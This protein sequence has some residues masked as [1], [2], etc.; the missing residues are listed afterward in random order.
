MK[1]L[2][3]FF[4]IILIVI[5]ISCDSDS[6]L[7]SDSKNNQPS[8]D[9]LQVASNTGNKNLSIEFAIPQDTFVK[10]YV[11][12][13][14]G[15]I[16]ITLIDQELQAGIHSVRWSGKNENGQSVNPGFY[17]VTLQVNDFIES[18]IVKVE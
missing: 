2:F 12:N 8:N 11:Q 17:F 6:L 1:H 15:D 18:A 4:I 3:Y 10:L 13:I 16:I 14:L 5:G 9:P 7:N